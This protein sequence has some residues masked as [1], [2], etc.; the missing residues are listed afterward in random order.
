MREITRQSA[1]LGEAVSHS[2]ASAATTALFAKK[3]FLVFPNEHHRSTYIERQKDE[4]PNDRNDRA[5]RVAAGYV[6][7]R[8]DAP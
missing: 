2:D 5:I 8:G 6:L 4:S 7:W 1:S 3:H